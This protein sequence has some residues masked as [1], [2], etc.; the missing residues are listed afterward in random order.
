MFPFSKKPKVTI[1]AKIYRAKKGKWYDL[2]VISKGK[3]KFVA[4]Q[5]PTP[6]KE[7]NDGVRTD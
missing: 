6:K 2:G 4:H 3:A 1:R 7:V 5:N